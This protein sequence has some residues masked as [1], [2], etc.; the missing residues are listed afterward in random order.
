MKM[1]YTKP[2]ILLNLL[3]GSHTGSHLARVIDERIEGC[4]EKGWNRLNMSNDLFIEELKEQM[5]IRTD[6][7][8]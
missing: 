7:N 6:D 2:K 3:R 5:R 8:Q 4:I 1:S